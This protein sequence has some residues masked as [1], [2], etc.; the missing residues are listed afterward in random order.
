[1]TVSNTI[2]EIAIDVGKETAKA[3]A[4]FT[5]VV[6]LSPE[7]GHIIA[8]DIDNRAVILKSRIRNKR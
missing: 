6:L 4:I 2:K 1:M 7:S 8:N 5:G 3:L